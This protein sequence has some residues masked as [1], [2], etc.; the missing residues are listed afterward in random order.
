MGDSEGQGGLLCCSPWT[1]LLVCL[2]RVRHDLMTEQ[3]QHKVRNWGIFSNLAG[4]E[5]QDMLKESLKVFLK[6]PSMSGKL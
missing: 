4:R 1:A 2:Q 3:Q 6:L 5:W